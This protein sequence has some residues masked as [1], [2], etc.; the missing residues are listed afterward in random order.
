MSGPLMHHI[1]RS[2]A[3]GISIGLMLFAASAGVSIGAPKK[4]TEPIKVGMIAMLASPENTMARLWRQL[5][6]STSA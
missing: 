4:R 2:K 6:F 3:V 5:G 1:V